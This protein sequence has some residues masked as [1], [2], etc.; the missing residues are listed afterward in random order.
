[1]A[2]QSFAEQTFAVLRPLWPEF[3]LWTVPT[4]Y[5]GT[6]WCARRIGEQTACVNANS[7]EELIGRLQEL[8]AQP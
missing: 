3:E 4:V 7:P 8:T 5:S 2:V 6:T 1:M